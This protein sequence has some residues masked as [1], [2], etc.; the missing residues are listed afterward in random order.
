MKKLLII[1]ILY[2]ILSYCQIEC[3]ICT[4]DMRDAGISSTYGK[5]GNLTKYICPNGHVSLPRKKTIRSLLEGI[6]NVANKHK[7]IHNHC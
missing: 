6:K 5:D 7:G 2:P 3:A 1:F 4:L